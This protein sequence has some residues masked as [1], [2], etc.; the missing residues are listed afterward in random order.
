MKQCLILLVLFAF[1]CGGKNPAA[2]SPAPPAPTKAVISVSAPGS[3]PASCGQI[4]PFCTANVSI[5][6][7]ESAG[8]GVTVTAIDTSFMTPDGI[9]VVTANYDAAKITTMAGTTHVA[10]GGSLIIPSP[11]YQERIGAF[12]PSAA[13]RVGTLTIV[14][15]MTDDRGNRFTGTMKVA[16][17]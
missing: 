1:A 12:W 14:A 8:V 6:V 2:P 3:W 13:G 11:G 16:I 9:V 15:Q 10:G 17:S 5:I 7:S 4:T